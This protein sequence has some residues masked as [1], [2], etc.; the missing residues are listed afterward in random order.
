MYGAL[1]SEIIETPKSDTNFVLE[2]TP[3]KLKQVYYSCFCRR[4]KFLSQKQVSITETSFCQRN[5]FLSKTQVSVKETS[6]KNKFL[7]LRQ[8][9]V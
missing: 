7:S 3:N 2:T 8:V 6:H 4:N 5:K 1:L 9:Y